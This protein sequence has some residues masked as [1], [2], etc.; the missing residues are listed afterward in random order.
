MRLPRF[1]AVLLVWL[2]PVL[3]GAA[4]FKLSTW[5]L[6]WLTLRPQGDAAL[7]DDVTVRD[8]ADFARLHWYATALNPDVVAVE[9]VD[10]PAPLAKLF[11]PSDYTLIFT[12]DDVVQRVGLAVRHGIG[13]RQNPDLRAL[14]VYPPEARFQLRSGLDATLTFPGGARLRLLAV[15][16]KT[17]C[18]DRKL[19]DRSR[20]CRALREQLRVLEPWIAA[21]EA[22]H[23]AFAVLGDFNRDMDGADSFFAGLAATA[24]LTRVTAGYAD[25]CWGGDRFIDHIL[26]GGPARAWLVPDSM[27]VLVYKETNPALRDALSDH[28]PVSVRLAP[29]P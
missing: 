16:L 28:C 9:E 18:W 22:E 23:V 19:S 1:L 15:H 26:L 8:A 27:R 10:G 25:P 7:P 24:P 4:P 14:D 3:A 12:H 17:G 11:P 5:N 2:V 29:R 6:D 13:V 21:R 20:A